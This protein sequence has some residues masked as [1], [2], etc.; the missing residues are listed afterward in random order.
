MRI[1]RKGEYALRAMIDLSL[2]FNKGSVQIH[3]I[4]EKE[5]I[6][7]KFL[8]HILLELKKAGLLQSKRGIGGGYWLI[9]PPEEITLAQVIRLIDGPL[10]PLGC[11]SEWAHISCPEEKNCGLQSV[12]LE[13]RN[14]IVKILE[15]ITFAD[16][17]KRTKG[18]LEKRSER[19]IK[20]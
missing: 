7:K 10:A 18:M 6:P 19:T 5:K 14:A 17:C 2:N 20:E 15:G 8:E 11:V 3:E 1:S 12:M 16:V 9:K 13:V 4:S